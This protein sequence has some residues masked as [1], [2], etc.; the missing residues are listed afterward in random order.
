MVGKAVENQVV[1]LPALGEILLRVIGD[2][3]GADGSHHVQIPRSGYAGHI[4]A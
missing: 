3:I 1:A 2:P 4:G